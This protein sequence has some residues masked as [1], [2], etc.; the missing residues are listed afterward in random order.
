METV[1]RATRRAA[2]PPASAMLLG[3]IVSFQLG[4]ALATRIFDHTGVIGAVFLR[5]AVGALL[6]LPFARPRLRGRGRRDLVPLVLLGVLLATMNGCFYQALDRLPQGVA[7]TVEF[8]GPLSVAVATSRRRLDLLWVAMAAVGVVLFTGSTDVRGAEL[9]GLLFALGAAAS[10][11][12]YILAVQRVGRLWPGYDGLAGSLVVSALLL[13]PLGAGRA[14]PALSDLRILGLAAAVGVFSTALPYMLEFSALRRM[15]AR[16]YGVLT[17][18]EPVAA[19]AVGLLVLGQHLRAIE[20]VAGLLVVGASVG[21]TQ[22]G[23]E[24]AEITPA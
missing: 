9:V 14:V 4:A 20:L 11:A 3:A 24:R 15:P 7:V 5:N 22:T 21:V 17:S 12:G 19:A 10:W 13:A 6:L 1:E 18:L 23:R 16:I 8:L 2:N